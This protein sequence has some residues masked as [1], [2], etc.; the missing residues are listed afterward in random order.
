MPGNVHVVCIVGCPDIRTAVFRHVG[1]LRTGSHYAGGRES[2]AGKPGKT[3]FPSSWSDER[4]L[5]EI[6]KIANDPNASGGIGMYDSPYKIGTV[7]G[8]K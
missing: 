8:V 3:E 7:D 2:D 4:I 1:A 5:Q 6:N